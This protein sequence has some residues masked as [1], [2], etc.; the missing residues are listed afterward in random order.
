[1]AELIDTG[2][3]AEDHLAVLDQD[4]DFFSDDDVPSSPWDFAPLD[5]WVNEGG[6]SW[7]EDD[8]PAEDLS[9]IDFDDPESM[10]LLTMLK[11]H[12][13]DACN[14]NSRSAARRRA[15]D[16]IFEPGR[17]DEKG[18]EFEPVCVALGARPIVLRTRVQMQLWRAGVVIDEPLSPFSVGLPDYFV[19]E[20][21]A[22]IG[23]GLVPELARAIW[24]WPSIPAHVL[25]SQFESVPI[26]AFS[27][28][29]KELDAN[30]FI[31]AAHLCFYFVGR[32]PETMP[33]A[34]L[35]RFSFARSIHAAY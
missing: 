3:S 14:I 31:A 18:L 2:A 10:Y 32:N 33:T 6:D 4:A 1:M 24:S 17:P 8:R 9:V 12:V 22:L 25:R 11:R 7:V 27:G 28:A 16:W 20:I 15:L 5:E 30:G 21:Q 35:R 26:E 23:Y 13:R 29:L 19:S 34:L